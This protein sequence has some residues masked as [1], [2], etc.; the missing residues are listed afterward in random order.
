M[1]KHRAAIALSTTALVVA[2]L[3]QTAVGHAAANAVR[4]ALFAQNSGRVNNIQASR[5][6][7]AGRLL[8]LNGK[9]QF[10]ASVIP[11]TLAAGARGT[12]G[13]YTHT[14][15]VHP[16]PNENK[17]GG[18]LINAMAR[19]TDNSEDNP[20]L[21][22]VEPGVYHLAAGSLTLKPYVDVEGSGE[23][24]TTIT[25][26]VSSGAGTVVG[27]DHAELRFLTVKNSGGGQQAVALFSESTSPRFTHVTAAASG[28]AENY[29]IH[30]SNGSPVLTN[31]TASA[32]GG[33]Q[34]FAVGNFNGTVTV[35]DSAFAASDAAGINVGLMTTFGG[36]VRL[37]SSSLSGT[38]GAIAIGMRSYSG[39]HSL[40]N[41]SITASGPNESYGMWNGQKTSAPS[42]TVNQSRVSGQTSVFALGG[43]VKIGA[44]QLTG[45]TALGEI[46]T[47]VCAASYN[48]SFAPLSS[49]CN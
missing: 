1:T 27:T 42:V 48:G 17:A 32:T 49:N 30:M 31:V 36:S 46:G 6:P 45:P 15:V 26:T 39:S 13:S 12:G 40:Q 25:S 10:P 11:Q 2:V 21:V 4:V 5:T 44:S 35:L 24:V 19:I 22:K 16:D 18:E 37:V 20:Y 43:S 33:S 7:M 8:A 28:A 3:G 34:S 23:G 41:V 29:G 47:I 38:G 14:I 9:G